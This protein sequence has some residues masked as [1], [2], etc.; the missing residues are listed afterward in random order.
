MTYVYT[1]NDGDK[2]LVKK[3]L[4]GDNRAFK[5]LFYKYKAIF[6]HK[7]QKWYSSYSNEEIQDMSMEFLGKISS[8]LSLYDP[9]KAK[10]STWMTKSMKNFM[11]EYSKRKGNKPIKG[12]CFDDIPEIGVEETIHQE[13]EN[14]QYRKLIRQMITSLGSEDTRLF[15]EVFLKGRKQ[16]EVAIEMNIKRSTF[17]YRVQRL[18]KRLEKFRPNEF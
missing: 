13:I 16:T 2:K 14:K 7:A 8:K 17:D 18:R 6:F 11:I 15:N 4:Q 12:V 1:D 9:Q 10:V 3:Y 5:P